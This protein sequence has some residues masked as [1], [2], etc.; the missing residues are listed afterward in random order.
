MP[1]YPERDLNPQSYC[2]K[3]VQ[4]RTRNINLG[5]MVRS[6]WNSKGNPWEP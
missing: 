3:T 1:T 6:Y 5:A 4:Y 2:S